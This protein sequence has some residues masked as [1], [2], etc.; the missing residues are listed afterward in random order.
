MSGLSF[1]ISAGISSISQVF[2]DLN[3]PFHS[4]TGVTCVK[5]EAAKKEV[6]VRVGGALW[7]EWVMTESQ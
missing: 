7:L 5:R 6:G 4:K 1:S 3:N 2:I